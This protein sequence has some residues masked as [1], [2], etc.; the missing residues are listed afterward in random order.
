MNNLRVWLS[1]NQWKNKKH[2]KHEIHQQLKEEGDKL[3][4]ASPGRGGLDSHRCPP[5]PQCFHA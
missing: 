1:E 5:G 3:T 2:T 4:A